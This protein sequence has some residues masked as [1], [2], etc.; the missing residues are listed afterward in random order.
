MRTIL[1]FSFALSFELICGCSDSAGAGTSDGSAATRDLATPDLTMGPPDL[2]YQSLIVARPYKDKIPAGYDPHKP[3]PLLI[4]LHGY[5]ADG[6]T[7]DAYFGL[8]NIVDQKGF[9]Y[10][11][12]DGVLDRMGHRFWNATDAC[13]DLYRTGVDDVAYVNAIIDDMSYKYNVDPKRIFVVGHS[14]G[15]FMSHQMAC[16]SSSRVAAIM[17]LAGDNWKDVTRCVAGAPVSV[18]QVHGDGDMVIHY[19]GGSNPYFPPNGGVM[20]AE[21][22]SARNSVASWVTRNGCQPMSMPGTPLDLD[23]GIAGAET[24]IDKWSG[25][26]AG[27]AVELWTIHGGGHVPGFQKTWPATFYD[28]LAAHPKQ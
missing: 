16:T 14:N 15:A 12:P 19:E 8:S 3:T 26:K 17:A 25:C 6:S 2:A 28:W 23:S 11:F 20:N 4:L 22:P 18:L 21:Y 27:T 7:Q 1:I 5:T 10:A 24:T 9:L 13:C